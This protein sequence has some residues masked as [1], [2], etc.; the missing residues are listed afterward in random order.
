MKGK[1][2][3]KG[4]MKMSDPAPH[5]IYAGADSNVA[6]EAKGGTDGFKRGGKA[7]AG[8]KAHGGMAKHH[9]GR[10][11]RKAGGGVFSSAGGPGEPRKPAQ[12]Y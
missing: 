9:A 2:K 12:H 7:K 8:M 4:G 11:P 6:K 5:D 10:K 1:S 3:S